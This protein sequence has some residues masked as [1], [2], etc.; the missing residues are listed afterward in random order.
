M[1][2]L[3]QVY[4]LSTDW[5]NKLVTDA[6]GLDARERHKAEFY[7]RQ[8]ANAVAPSN[9]VLTNPELL[10]ETL[11][12]N[13]ENLV[14]GMQMLSLRTSR[15]AAAT[16]A[17]ANRISSRFEVGRNTRARPRQGRLSERADAAHP[18][19]A[20]DRESAQGPCC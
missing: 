9:F 18:I 19:H 12:S 15:P 4:L 2:S 20:D 10:R 8:I 11:S 16:C 1:I 13:A 3:K 6:Q 14:R 17:S 7:M 5:A